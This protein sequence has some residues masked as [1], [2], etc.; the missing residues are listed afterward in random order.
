M[1]MPRMSRQSY[2]S[3]GKGDIKVEP[4]IMYRSPQF[5]LRLSKTSD[6]LS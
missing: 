3:D 2:L 1:I 5:T 4:D 6:N